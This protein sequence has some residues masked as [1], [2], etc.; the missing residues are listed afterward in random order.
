MVQTVEFSIPELLERIR[1]G[2]IP[3]TATAQVTFDEAS[4]TNDEQPS[5][6]APTT[7]AERSA[8]LALFE[9]WARAGAA[10]TPQE[11]VENDRIYAEIEKTG[12]SRAHI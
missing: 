6:A 1:Q 7:E 11:R 12:I 10:S 5:T 4:L 3:L 9:Q 2:R 8:D